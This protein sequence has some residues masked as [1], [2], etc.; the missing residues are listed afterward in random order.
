MFQF[1]D[2]LI[3]WDGFDF[4]GEFLIVDYGDMVFDYVKILIF[5]GL[6]I[7]YFCII[8][9][10]GLGIVMLGGDYFIILLIL[11]V[12]VEKYGLMLVIQFDVYFDLWVDDDFDWIDYG[13]FMYKVVKQGLVDVS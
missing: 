6:V 11:W 13:I 1:Y 3:G 12:Y 2:L 4:L 8:L 7:D 5:L 9:V 10:V